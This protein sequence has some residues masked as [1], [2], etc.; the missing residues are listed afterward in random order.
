MITIGGGGR[1]IN[2]IMGNIRLLK[3][4]GGGGNGGL[5]SPNPEGFGPKLL[6]AKNG[7]IP[8]SASRG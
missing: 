7:A 4:G 8:A 2:G 1:P 5:L 3:N 6:A